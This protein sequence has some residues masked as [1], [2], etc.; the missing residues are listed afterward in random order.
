VS[1]LREEVTARIAAWLAAVRRVR[2]DEFTYVRDFE[3][4]SGQARA[5]SWMWCEVL[6]TPEAS[7][8]NEAHRARHG[9]H[10]AAAGTFDLLRHEY[11]ACGLDLVVTEARNF[12]L[13]DVARESVDILATREDRRAGAIRRIARL[14]FASDQ[15]PA[16]AAI[17]EGTTFELGACLD[18][19]L[20][21]RCEERTDGGICCGCLYFVRYKKPAQRV[22]YLDARQWFDED[23]RTKR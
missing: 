16:Q 20:L 19:M 2:P 23:F 14:L 15:G 12:M 8:H 7:P 10:I 4:I 22:G 17:G 1:A 11:V 13:V 21:A 3:E 18:P 5:D 9:F 6:F